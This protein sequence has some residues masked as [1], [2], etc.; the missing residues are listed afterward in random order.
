MGQKPTQEYKSPKVH[1]IDIL[2]NP[3]FLTSHKNFFIY[4]QSDDHLSNPKRNFLY[5][6]NLFSNFLKH[7]KNR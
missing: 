1:V 3:N 7:F 5:T 4:V 6:Y 2:F